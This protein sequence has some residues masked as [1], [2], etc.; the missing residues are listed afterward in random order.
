M[1][2]ERCMNFSRSASAGKQGCEDGGSGRDER[3]A[4]PTRREGSRPGGNAASM[5]LAE[6][7]YLLLRSEA[8]VDQALRHAVPG[9]VGGAAVSRP[10]KFRISPATNTFPAGTSRDL[11]DDPEGLKF[12]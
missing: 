3:S 2:P 9:V 12:A 6:A 4:Q 1:N 8:T 11:G 5:A 10:T 7:F